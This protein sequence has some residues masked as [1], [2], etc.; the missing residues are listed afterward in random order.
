MNSNDF[1][2]MFARP[3]L[4]TERELRPVANQTSNLADCCQD[5][6]V[7]CPHGD[8]PSVARIGADS[9]GLP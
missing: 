2:D 6:L 8:V 3:E 1:G 5:L 4:S 7:H 9:Y